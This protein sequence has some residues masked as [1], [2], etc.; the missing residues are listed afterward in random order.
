LYVLGS[1]N[2]DEELHSSNSSHPLTPASDGGTSDSQQL[3]A[4]QRRT[5]KMPRSIPPNRYCLPKHFGELQG[6]LE[7]KR[8]LNF[9]Q[10][11]SLC[12]KLRPSIEEFTVAPDTDTLS[13]IVKK[14][15]IQLP[16]I[17]LDPNNE[18]T[19]VVTIVHELY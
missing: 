9:N 8:A 6:L 16:F 18:N 12:R 2:S 3:Q 14:L 5:K 13:F 15:F 10:L 4:S 11:S 17:M 1:S 7:A 19:S